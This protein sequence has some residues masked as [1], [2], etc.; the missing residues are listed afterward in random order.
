MKTGAKV[1]VAPKPKVTV[2]LPTQP[3]EP[4]TELRDYTMLWYGA[5]GIGKTT[6]AAEFPGA[7]FINTEPGTKAL[8][9][10]STPARNWEQMVATIDAIV[11]DKSGKFKTVIVDTVDL[12]YEYAF[13]HICKKKMIAHPNEENDFG[14]TWKEIKGAFREQMGRLMACKAV[15]FLSHDTEKEIELRDGNK[16][17]RVQPTMASQALNEIEGIV[18][19]VGHYCF[20]RDVRFMRLVG[21]QVEVAKCRCEENFV[22]KGGKPRTPG[23]KILS[24]P[25]GLTPQ[26]SY[27]NLLLAFN[28]GQVDVDPLTSSTSE[29]VVKKSLTLKKK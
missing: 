13:Q 9:V 8:R 3:S 10:Y 4:A 1:P 29:P 26:E 22:R 15:V 12:A 2:T 21:S 17:D 19:I 20:E 5:K 6:L 7:L 16:V 28:N 27:K 11:A 23:D 25:M 24:I 14:Q 18:D